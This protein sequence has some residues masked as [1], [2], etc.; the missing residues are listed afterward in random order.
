VEQH[1]CHEPVRA[2]R[3]AL[4]LQPLCAPRGLGVRARRAGG[5]RPLLQVQL[6]GSFSVFSPGCS[7]YSCCCWWCC[8]CCCWCCCCCCAGLLGRRKA[9]STVL[10]GLLLLPFLALLCASGCVGHHHTGGLRHNLL[11]HHRRRHG[12]QREPAPEGT[13]VQLWSC[14]YSPPGNKIN[15]YPYGG[16]N[17]PPETPSDPVTR[18]LSLLA[19]LWACST[20]GAAQSARQ[21]PRQMSLLAESLAPELRA[22]AIG[23]PVPKL[24]G[25]QREVHPLHQYWMPISSGRSQGRVSCRSV[26]VF[27]G[28]PVR[29][30]CYKNTCPADS[31]CQASGSSAICACG[32]GKT[33]PS[34]ANKCLSGGV[35]PSLFPALAVRSPDLDGEKAC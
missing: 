22:T 8:W 20:S 31:T 23:S 3:G 13:A 4:R 27:L 17:S 18:L 7:S 24:Q 5:L 16:W 25:L 26:L 6:Q 33:W 28:C 32:A 35:G 15:Q 12:G 21:T 30:P 10:T 11:H 14:H 29:S 2:G 19:C 34:S 9:S 1:G